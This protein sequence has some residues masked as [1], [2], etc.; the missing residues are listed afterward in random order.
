MI[1]LETVLFIAMLNELA[2]KTAKGF[3]DFHS[4]DDANKIN[5]FTGIL[6]DSKNDNRIV[7]SK[8]VIPGDCDHKD[9]IG[10]YDDVPDEADITKVS[11][12]QFTCT[13]KMTEHTESEEQIFGLNHFLYVHAH[14]VDIDGLMYEFDIHDGKWYS[15]I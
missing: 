7:L 10:Y 13:V 2:D 3:M 6:Y 15:A 4:T 8:L 1:N 12:V 9:I 14:C 11:P 5:D